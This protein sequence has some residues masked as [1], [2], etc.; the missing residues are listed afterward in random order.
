MF[1]ISETYY[2]DSSPYTLVRIVETMKDFKYYF[3][4][5]IKNKD[6]ILEVPK[7]GHELSNY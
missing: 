4:N 3:S 2:F 5:A 6:I 7:K 1:K